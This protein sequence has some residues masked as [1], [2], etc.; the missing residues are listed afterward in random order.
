ML[1]HDGVHPHRRVPV[2]HGFIELP[3]RVSDQPCFVMHLGRLRVVTFLRFQAN[4]REVR[5]RLR[6]ARIQLQ[7]LFEINFSL[8]QLFFLH[9]GDTG[10]E[11][12]VDVLTF[13]FASRAVRS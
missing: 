2:P 6:M 11:G 10:L 5:A 7:Y 8:L 3:A 1:F 12:A 4:H 13:F 9:G